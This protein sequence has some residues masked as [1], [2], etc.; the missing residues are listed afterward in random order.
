MIFWKYFFIEFRSRISCI[1]NLTI[2][3]IARVVELEFILHSHLFKVLLLI[4]AFAQTDNPMI[5]KPVFPFFWTQIFMTYWTCKDF[6]W[7]Y[8]RLIH[9]VEISFLNSGSSNRKIYLDLLTSPRFVSI[10]LI[11]SFG[12]E[13][14]T[15][16]IINVKNEKFVYTVI[17]DQ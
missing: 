11:I 17:I 9:C 8:L 15:C 2:Y 16:S 1:F 7:R 3:R 14:E 6:K 5:N 4:M 10:F 13:I 12:N